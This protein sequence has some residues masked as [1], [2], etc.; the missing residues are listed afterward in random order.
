[1]VATHANLFEQLLLFVLLVTLVPA[2]SFKCHQNGWRCK[3][4]GCSE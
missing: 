2:T 3:Q 1:M 4:R